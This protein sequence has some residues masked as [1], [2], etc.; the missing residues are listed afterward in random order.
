MINEFEGKTEQE[1]V[2]KAVAELNMDES[3]FDVEV[4]DEGHSGLFFKKPVRIKVTVKEETSEEKSAFQ[5][6]FEEELSQFN[7]TPEEDENPNVDPEVVDKISNFTKEMISLMGYEAD[8]M[9][10]SIK[11]TKLTLSI[12]SESDSILI[13]RKGKNL[14]ALQVIANAYANQLDS[15]CKVILDSENYRIRH[16]KQ[17]VRMAYRTAQ[18]VKKTGR[19]QLLEPMNPYERRL[20][21]TALND[22]TGIETKSEGE[23]LFKQVRVLSS[24]KHH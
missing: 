18:Q 19:S 3:C 17:I 16:E 4:L 6:A 13:G 23:G 7:D 20:V 8:I 11:G 14:D 21:H 22:V 9:T 10:D 15:D 24:R 12:Q 1:A 5:Q 2:A